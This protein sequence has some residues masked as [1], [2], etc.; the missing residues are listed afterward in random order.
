MFTSDGR[1]IR[2][3]DPVDFTNPGHVRDGLSA[4]SSTIWGTVTYGE[5][6]GAATYGGVPLSE[7]HVW[8]TFDDAGPFP[9]RAGEDSAPGFSGPVLVPVSWVRLDLVTD[10]ES[11]AV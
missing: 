4:L 3:G 5:P 6:V 10:N 11:E 2:P 8:A 9:G 7:P 1:R